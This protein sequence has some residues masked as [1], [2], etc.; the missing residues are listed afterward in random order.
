MASLLLSAR[1]QLNQIQPPPPLTIGQ[2]PQ[3]MG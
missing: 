3:E 2:K 1:Q